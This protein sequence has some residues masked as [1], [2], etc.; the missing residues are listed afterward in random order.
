MNSTRPVPADPADTENKLTTIEELANRWHRCSDGL[1][2]RGRAEGY[3][4]AI[5]LL[6]GTKAS[7]VRESLKEGLL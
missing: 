5:A 3:V 6:L 2:D 4:Q 7:T 1:F